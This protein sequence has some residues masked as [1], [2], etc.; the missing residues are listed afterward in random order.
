M[1]SQSLMML[2]LLL[3]ISISCKPKVNI[4]P[5]SKHFNLEKLADGVYAAIPNP[6]GG[7]AICNAGIID[8]GD[9]TVVLDPFISPI[10]ARDLKQLAE[11]LTGKPVSMVLNLDPHNDH[12][13]GNQVFVPEADIVGTPNARTYISNNF[14]TDY[15]YYKENAPKKL[16]EIQKQLKVAT[17]N[18]KA[19]LILWQSEYQ[20]I[21]E[22]LPELKMSLPNV[23][24][25]DTMIIYGSKRRIVII[26]TGTGHTNGD[27]VTWLPE[28]RIIFMSD[29]LFVKAHPYLGDGNPESLKNNLKQIIALNPDIAV[30]GHGPVGDVNSLHAMVD[31]IETLTD[32]VK[33]EIQKG[34]D[35]NK[36]LE[37]AMPEKYNDWVVS[38]FYKINL[39][40]LY[41]KLMSKTNPE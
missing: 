20:A 18:E 14:K 35:E 34:T 36:V 5:V 39:K 4:V 7:Y 6:D 12:N 31:Y 17:G 23:V 10:A 19:E 30:P 32:M 11:C 9:K 8:L 26:P 15:E 37:L 27:M 28:D 21:I 3:G 29:Q 38:S 2:T 41:H 1:K 22:S 16:L 40:F 33:S 13:G 24:I 25:N